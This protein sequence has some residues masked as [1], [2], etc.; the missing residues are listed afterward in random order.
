MPY[1]VLVFAHRK[2]GVTPEQFRAHYDE[3]HVP[4]V[5]ELAGTAF[6]LSHTRRYPLLPEAQKIDDNTTS[7]QNAPATELIGS[8]HEFDYDAY[9]EL[10]FEDESAFQTFFA[11]TQRPENI[12]KISADEEMF[13]DRTR[14]TVVV[15][16][17]TTVTQRPGGR[18]NGL[19]HIGLLKAS[20]EKLQSGTSAL[21]VDI[22]WVASFF[23]RFRRL[24][25]GF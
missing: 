12:I 15:V 7:D 2:R 16:G 22:H 25:R 24:L 19:G 6:P 3:V 20:Q 4:L 23:S 14:M 1:S 13:L 8:E 11:L 9:V 17:D 5:R 18:P 21:L 10:T